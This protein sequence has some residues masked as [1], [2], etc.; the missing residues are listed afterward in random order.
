MQNSLRI[1]RLNKGRKYNCLFFSFS[2]VCQFLHRNNLLSIIRAHECQME[3]YEM[4]LLHKIHF[5]FYK[6]LWGVGGWGGLTFWIWRSRGLSPELPVL[7]DWSEKKEQVVS[8]KPLLKLQ[9]GLL[10]TWIWQVQKI[11]QWRNRIRQVFVNNC[12]FSHRMTTNN[13]I[14]NFEISLERFPINFKC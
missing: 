12:R 2:A 11:K 13:L 7:V 10:E 5:Y 3:G 14:F 4:T 1:T 9:S 8:R 6:I